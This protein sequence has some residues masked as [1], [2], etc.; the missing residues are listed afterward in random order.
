MNKNQDTIYI[1]KCKCRLL[2]EQLEI[3]Y[4]KKGKPSNKVCPKHGEFIDKRETICAFPGCGISFLTSKCG[5]LSTLCPPHRKE[6]QK[7]K[8]AEKDKLSMRLRKSRIAASAD[9]SSNPDCKFFQEL[10]NGCI[11]TDL[12]SCKM[13][14]KAA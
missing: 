11:V 5:K 3:T 9:L 1:M 4:T 6:T 10:C 8:K 13:Y 12:V 14:N 7:I 2:E